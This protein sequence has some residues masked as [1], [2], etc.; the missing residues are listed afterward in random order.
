MRG[1]FQNRRHLKNRA[2]N[3]FATDHARKRC[4]ARSPARHACAPLCYLRFSTCIVAEPTV[5]RILSR[6]LNERLEASTEP[7]TFLEIASP[8]AIHPSKAAQFLYLV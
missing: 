6:S 5:R 3:K 4:R 8:F 2:R 1:Q 7:S